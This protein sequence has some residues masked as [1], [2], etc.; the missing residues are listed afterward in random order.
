[1]NKTLKIRDLTLRDGQQSLFAT[2]MNQN[3][4]DRV[5]AYYKEAGF[6]AMEVWGGAVPDAIMRF[7]KEN[8]W[9]RL[10]KIHR[11]VGSVSKLTALSRG[12]NLFGYNP[13]PEHVIEGFNRNAVQS[14]IHIMRI[15]DALNDISNIRSTI[16][17]VKAHGG[18]ADCCVCY[19]IDPKFTLRERA[20]AFWQMKKVPRRI[21]RTEYFVN[22]AKELESMGADMIT[23]KDMAGL[24]PPRKAAKIISRLKEELTVPIDFHTHCTPGYG[25]ASTL[26]AIMNG[27]DIVDTSILNFSGGPAAPTFEI[28]QLFCNKLGIDT[29]VNISVIGTINRELGEIRKEMADIDNYPH[30]REFD[31]TRDT[32]PEEVDQLF[33]QAIEAAGKIDEEKLLEATQAIE[34]WFGLPE[35]NEEVKNAEI[36]GGMYTNMISQLKQLKLD[37]LMTRVLEVVP[38]VR[39]ASGCPPLVTPTSQIVGAQAVNYVIDENKKQKPYTTKNNQ[40]VSLVKGE[41]GKTPIDIDPDFRELICGN[42]EETPYNID[43]YKKQPNPELELAGSRLLAENEKEE[44]LLELF[45][46]VAATF[47]QEWKENEFHALIHEEEIKR[48]AAHLAEKA[49]FNKL[50]DEEK[51]KRLLEGLYSYNWSS[52]D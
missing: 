23:I 39:L 2:R 30:P 18:I 37:H 47:L 15:F 42:P 9:D 8:P 13:Y 32:L 3:Q 35:P 21:F 36:P 52:D 1:M 6:Y 44:L 22:K 20:R 27:V 4:V 46:Q 7:L 24:V 14:G 33:D 10:E 45:P 38:V 16:G 19:T 17:Y 28:V 43:N 12:R 49:A 29:G 5:L 48:V 11:E 25:L 40:F 31:L 34:R 50:S 41:Y 26:V 51:K